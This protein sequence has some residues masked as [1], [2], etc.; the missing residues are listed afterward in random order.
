MKQR[1]LLLVLSV[2]LF[3][4]LSACS[5]FGPNASSSSQLVDGSPLG[6]HF[7]TRK[8]HQAQ[9]ALIRDWTVQGSIAARSD[10][11]GW[12]ASYNWQ[13]QNDNYTLVLFG[14]FGIDRTQLSGNPGKVTLTTA[15][16]QQFTANSPE[17]LIQQQLGWSLPVTNLYYWLRGLPAPH[18]LSRQSY[19]INNHVVDLYQQGWHITY[20]RYIAVNG[21]DLPDRILLTN[22]QWQ[23]RLVITK[24]QV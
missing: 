13:Q 16:Q 9:V 12:N 23:V 17:A 22:A 24:W 2:F 14:P 5:T 7:M 18:M 21:I 4:L 1:S 10:Q 15:A 20:L 19:D 6:N 11:K 3:S 8:Q